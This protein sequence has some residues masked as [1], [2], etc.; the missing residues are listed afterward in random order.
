[1]SIGDQSAFPV[2]FGHGEGVLEAP[3]MTYRQYLVGKTLGGMASRLLT[4]DGSDLLNRLSK[5]LGID[6]NEAI[7]RMA[8]EMAD[9]TLKK[10]E[11]K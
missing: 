11:E 2:V 3:G 5:T 9:A 8:I 7:A 1:M 10:L 6:P 4:T